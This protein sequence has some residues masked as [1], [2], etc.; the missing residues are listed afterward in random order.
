CRKRTRRSAVDRPAGGN[1]YVAYSDLHLFRDERVAVSNNGGA[2]FS[3]DKEID[4]GPHPGSVVSG[5][6]IATD[7][8]GNVYSIFGVGAGISPG[9]SNVTY[10]LNRSRDGGL[11]WDFNPNSA[12][13][14]IVIDSGV[15][16]QACFRVDQ[17]GTCTQAS[18]N[19]F[20]GV[21]NLLGN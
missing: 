8:A 18:N 14:G 17:G 2:T 16:A 19:W 1:V 9:V 21:N 3:T 4:N 5:T 7:N 6:R 13:G 12:I 10:Y 20:A 15:S 11:T